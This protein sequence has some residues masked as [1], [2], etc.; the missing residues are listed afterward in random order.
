MRLREGPIKVEGKHILATSSVV[1]GTLKSFTEDVMLK[2]K[3]IFYDSSLLE[4]FSRWNIVLSI[5]VEKIFLRK[6]SNYNKKYSLVCVGNF[7]V[8]P[9]PS[10]HEKKY[11]SMYDYFF[12][13]GLNVTLKC[14]FRPEE[15]REAC[16][17][18]W[19]FS[20]YMVGEGGGHNHWV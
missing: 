9:P 13:S 20:L 12:W 1:N 15:Q 19:K 3:L 8:L 4:P 7:Q 14:L 16:R 6:I 17:S 18:K 2:K 10:W 5:S 11:V